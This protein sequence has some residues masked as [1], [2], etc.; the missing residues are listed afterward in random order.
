[1]K[2]L[3]ACLM[4]IF[5]PHVSAQDF[6]STAAKAAKLQYEREIEAAKTNYVKALED[7]AKDAVTRDRL[8]DAVEIKK[9]IDELKASSSSKIAKERRDLWKHKNGY[10][11]KLNDGFWVERVP[12]GDAMIFAP[13]METDEYIEISRLTGNRAVVRLYDRHSELFAKGTRDFK[14]LYRG[15]WAAK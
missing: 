8:E 11:E 10:F 7:A 12:N 2:Y 4:L 3:L 9:A 14:T 6:E 13:G 1:M 15:G 5:V